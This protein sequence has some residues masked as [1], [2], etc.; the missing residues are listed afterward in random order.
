MFTF[1]RCKSEHVYFHLY[2]IQEQVKLL[3]DNKKIEK[4]LQGRKGGINSLESGKREGGKF[5][6]WI[7]VRITQMYTDLSKVIEF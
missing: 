4:W 3:Y 6:I 1:T 7:V 5:F 2:E